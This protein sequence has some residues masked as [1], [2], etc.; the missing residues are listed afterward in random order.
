MSCWLDRLVR[1]WGDKM[2]LKQKLGLFS[3]TILSAGLATM[4]PAYAQDT[5]AQ[6]P[7][8]EESGEDDIVVTGSRIRRD[9]FN[10][11]SPIQVITA[12]SATL[13]GLVD[14]ADIIQGSSIAAGSF[15]IRNQFG[16]FV[17]DGGTGVNTVSLR[18]LG[19]QRSLILVNGRRPGP[20]GVR[21]AVG[22]FDLN[23]IPSS[24]VQRYE[25]LKDGASS[26]YG[27]DAVAGVVNVITLDRVD[28]PTLNVSYDAPFESGG[29]SYS[30]DG[31][32]GLNFDR[33]NIVIAA[34]YQDRA[35][36]DVGDRDYLSCSQDLVRSRTTGNLIDRE[37]RSI[38]AGTNL[39]GCNNIYFNTVIDAVFGTRYIPDPAGG[40][41]NGVIPG[42]RPRGNQNYPQG[43]PNTAF[44]ED[45]LNDARFLSTDAINSTQRS[46]LFMTSNFDLDVFGG[47]EWRNEL[48]F[49][50]RETQSDG[51]RQFF[52]LIGGA[53]AGVFIDPSYAYANDPAFD[54]AVGFDNLLFQPITIWPSNEE[55]T[56]DYMSFSTQFDG[57]FN[58]NWSWTLYGTY[59]RSEGE[60]GGNAIIASESGDVQFDADAPI[61]D[62]Y[63]FD[64]LSGNYGDAV[65]DALTANIVGTTEYEQTVIS[66]Y[67]SG[68]LFELPA[69]PLSAAFGAEYRNYSINDTPDALSQAG[70]LWGQSSAQVT[71]GEDTV[72]EVFAELEIPILRGVTLFEDLTLNVSGRMFEYDSYGDD[73]VWSAGLNWQ[74]TPTFRVRGTTGTSYRAPG[75]FELFLGNQTGFLGQAGIDP[76]IDWGNSTNP[77]IQA[78][79]AAEGIPD[80]YAGVGSSATIVSGGGAG[81]L[82]AETSEAN[83]FGIVWTPTFVNL[84]V[85]VDYFE[86]TVLD[87]I[88]QLGAG[89]IIGG[90]YGANNY[91]NAFCSLFDRNPASHPTDPFLITE[92]RDSYINV[93]EQT[94]DGIDLTVRY[95]HEFDFGSLLMEAQGTWTFSDVVF[96]F[97]PDLESGFDTSDFNG[98]IG[99]PDF[100]A[101]SRISLERGDWT[102]SWFTNFISRT[103]QADFVAA[104]ITYQGVPATRKI[105]AEATFYHDTSV[106]WRGD[107][108]SILFG[109][110]NVFDE[111]PPIVSTGATTRRGNVPAFGTQYDLRG[112]AAF[113]QF[114][115]EF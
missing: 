93:N 10:S 12:E 73:S 66:G 41:G 64:F 95:E 5:P 49:T 74:M 81:V 78:N 75:L 23:V 105:H 85:A 77:N 29:E 92:V 2:N 39:A 72:Q 1:N 51:W 44:Y 20:A 107:S 57:E 61:Y 37:D 70:D 84:S 42:Y 100:V 56:V 88:A 26:I 32:F 4:A 104:D 108:M 103:S 109:V 17:V 87:Q 91:P 8:A 24:I 62:P 35:E 18:G 96:L 15:Q 34:E 46:S 79:C 59:S 99:D 54:L 112:R 9:E 50:R 16:G 83:T 80:D 98:S 82:E 47:V 89:T 11:S 19:A 6:Q 43:D 14:T 106:R 30:I 52:P 71:A 102:Y 22:A 110:S 101:N 55:V 63:S 68:D 58:S 69:G 76:C 7:A 97:D 3:A 33:G 25:I 111:A 13:E 65:Y 94:T 40:P 48:L 36:L 60:Y 113:L 86:I 21:G 28:A 38:L 45:V 115:K 114:T 67:V 53:S 27:S 31:A 90:C